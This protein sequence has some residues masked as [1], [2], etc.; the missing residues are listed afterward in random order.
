MI[1]G[2]A[3]IDL[4]AGPQ[5][6]APMHWT[7]KVA[8]DNLPV[9]WARS[10]RKPSIFSPG[11]HE[12]QNE[13]PA[14]SI[15]AGAGASRQHLAQPLGQLGFREPYDSILEVSRFGSESDRGAGRQKD[16][17][18][19]VASR[20]PTE[21]SHEFHPAGAPSRPLGLHPGAGPP[22]HTDF[23]KSSKSLLLPRALHQPRSP[24]EG[25]VREGRY[26]PA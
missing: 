5:G 16:H 20:V 21:I 19:V 11:A 2:I 10:S 1:F 6:R 3:R 4:E 12:V 23:R 7:S 9:D 8:F 24:W 25:W 22:S 15:D 26:L 17:D 18:V 13:Y 14:L